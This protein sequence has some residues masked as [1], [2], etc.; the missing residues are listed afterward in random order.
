M[1]DPFPH[2]SSPSRLRP[3]TNRLNQTA[4]VFHHVELTQE[5]EICK[6]LATKNLTTNGKLVIGDLSFQNQVAINAFAASIPD[7]WEDEPYWLVDEAIPALEKDG[8]NVNY[9]QVSA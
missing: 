9:I 1:I 7:P 8:L 5:A 4:Y 6:T 3:T 2:P